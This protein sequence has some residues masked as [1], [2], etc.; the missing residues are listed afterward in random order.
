MLI[1][2]AAV[3][4]AKQILL[5]LS[6]LYFYGLALATTFQ[7]GTY[8]LDGPAT[9]IVMG[10]VFLLA[11]FLEV[12]VTWWPFRARILAVTL[13]CLG[14]AFLGF[15]VAP[16]LYGGQAAIYFLLAPVAL[17]FVLGIS[18]G[19]AHVIYKHFFIPMSMTPEAIRA[20]LPAYPGWR[21]E[22]GGLEKYFRFASFIQALNFVNKIG[23]LAQAGHREP[24]IALTQGTVRLRLYYPD[25][26]GVTEED[27]VMAKK[28]E[29]I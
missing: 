15:I 28:V 24:D 14:Y 13:L 8:G 16:A 2:Y 26:G 20:A 6:V 5:V 3:Q 27:F 4:S 11:L 10:S 17:T 23:L 7:W 21:Y 25:A 9:F 19:F 18:Y 29:E 1:P 22:S 12:L